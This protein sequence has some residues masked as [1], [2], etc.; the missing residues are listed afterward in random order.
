MATPWISIIALGALLGFLGQS[1]RVIVGLKKTRDQAAALGKT[2][3]EALEPSTLFTSLLIGAVAGALAALMILKP[4]AGITP[5]M[6]L[7]LAAAGYSGA[8]FVEGFLARRL[9][10]GSIQPAAALLEVPPVPPSAPGAMT[11]L[12]RGPA[13]ITPLPPS[14]PA[15]A[16][17]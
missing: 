2:F 12:A 8:D 11:P 5:E 6:L 7:G 16:G 17:G 3:S 4:D 9:A 13:P 1:V 10:A 14:P 15:S